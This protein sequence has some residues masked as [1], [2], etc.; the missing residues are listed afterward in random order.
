MKN[1]QI[2]LFLAIMCAAL[3]GCQKESS[4]SSDFPGNAQPDVQTVIKFSV[5]ERTY[6][7]GSVQQKSSYG[8]SN[9]CGG[10]GCGEASE[11]FTDEWTTYSAGNLIL[12]T[13]QDDDTKP[14][15]RMSLLG[16]IDLNTNTFPANVSN[17]RI[18]LND[19]NGALIQPNDD[20][21]YNTGTLSFEGT[22]DAVNLTLTSRNGN[23][24]EG[25]FNGTLKMTN[26]S[27]LEIR[28]GTFR[29]QLRGL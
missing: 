24:V 8:T 23:V 3:F 28:D 1:S 4:L 9:G 27:A 17:A 6:E 25:T 12:V 20:P 7:L 19:F 13:R 21:A 29:A 26:G 15:F 18:T 5:G 10:A 11:D 22:Q 14:N 16:I 2:L